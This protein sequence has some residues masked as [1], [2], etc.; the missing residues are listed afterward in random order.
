MKQVW[1]GP[2]I[3]LGPGQSG[4]V[5]KVLHWVSEYKLRKMYFKPINGVQSLKKYA[6]LSLTLILTAKTGAEEKL[7]ANKSKAM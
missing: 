7:K 3:G 2:L 4:A 6:H 5:A 1:R